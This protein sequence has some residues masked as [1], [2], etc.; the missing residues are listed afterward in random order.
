[1]SIIGFK[2]APRDSTREFVY[3]ERVYVVDAV[4][5][6]ARISDNILLSLYG[7]TVAFWGSA[8]FP[9]DY[10]KGKF[11]VEK[12][13][14]MQ[15]KDIVSNAEAMAGSKI[16]KVM[17]TIPPY[18]TVEKYVLNL[19]AELTGLMVVTLV[20]KGLTVGMNYATSRT[21][22]EFTDPCEGRRRTQCIQAWQKDKGLC[23]NLLF[24]D[25]ENRMNVMGEIQYD[26][27]SMTADPTVT[28]FITSYVDNYDDESLSSLGRYVDN[29]DDESL[30]SLGPYVDKDITL[31][32]FDTSF[33]DLDVDITVFNGIFKGRLDGTSI[34]GS[35]GARG[36]ITGVYGVKV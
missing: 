6:A 28:D 7:S 12:L 29:Y 18:F 2:P 24:F 10:S 13:L 25:N 30:S 26:S 5:L 23:P 36:N 32:N 20:I 31:T 1:M 16:K 8:A 11:T 34:A 9:E 4:N 3:P 14:A 15:L 35:L 22:N 33:E 21:F 19:M 27:A 17:F